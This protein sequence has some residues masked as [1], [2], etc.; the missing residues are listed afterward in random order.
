MNATPP[1]PGRPADL[2]PL[3]TLRFAAAL[4]VV[5]YDYWPNL[6]G[7]D[8]PLPGVLAKGYL[9]VEL[10]FVLSGFI[11]AHVYLESA[12]RGRFGYGGFLWNRLA[13]VYPLH[14]A[15]L[16]AV[17]GMGIG[18]LLMGVTLQHSVL[19][20][21]SLPANVLL[22][23]AWGLA[24][25]AAFNHPSWSI[26]AEWFAYLA[27]PLF[28]AAAWW[29]RA[30]PAVAGVAALALLVTTYGIFERVTGQPLTHATLFWGALRVV[31]CFA[32]GCAVFL[33]WRSGAVKTKAEALLGTALAV[34]AILML[35]SAG[36]PDAATVAVFGGLI[37]G[38][39]GLSSTG[40][41]VLAHPVGVYL[42]E[43]SFAVY[44]VCI[45]WRLAVLG[46]AGKVLHLGSGPLPWPWW[47]AMT[48]G[49]LPAAM[50]AHHLVERPARS[51]MR[52]LASKRAAKQHTATK[53]RVT[54]R[55]KGLFTPA[56]EG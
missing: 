48:A 13:R 27:F 7:E 46:V 49:L 22:V 43:V 32:W 2:K 36:A 11:L 50:L 9:G 41:R 15:T 30:R 40:S 56:I 5:L 12:G 29:L 47:L 39:A 17:A 20:W 19:D 33:M 44:M 45:P 55:D 37:L 24:P 38:L 3:T 23:H 21:A 34:L 35:G 53:Q 54:R 8:H 31:P 42:G 28:A 52:Q 25:A 1:D 26:S 4:W 16:L 6:A 10:F 18:A 51:A 14:L